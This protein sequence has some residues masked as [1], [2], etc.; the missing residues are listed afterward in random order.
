MQLYIAQ[1]VY[2]QLSTYLGISMSP[3]RSTDKISKEEEIILC[4]T[5]QKDVKV[6]IMLIIIM[7]SLTVF[8]YTIYD[9]CSANCTDLFIRNNCT[10]F[11][12]IHI[13]NS[14]FWHH[15]TSNVRV[16]CAKP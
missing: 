2:I 16:Y 8:I 3:T 12:H 6:L 4:I 13:A 14:Q 11:I 7:Y 15:A 1:R 10:L 5:V 9:D